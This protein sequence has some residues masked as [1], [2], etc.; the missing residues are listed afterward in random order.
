[1]F[2]SSYIRDGDNDRHGIL[3]FYFQSYGKLLF[4]YS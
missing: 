1:M 4:R 3:G 2:D